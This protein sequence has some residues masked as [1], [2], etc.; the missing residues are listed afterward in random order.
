MGCGGQWWKREINQVVIGVIQANPDDGLDRGSQ[1]WSWKELD[2]VAHEVAL[3]G[4]FG[5]VNGSGEGKS[6]MLGFGLEQ[7]DT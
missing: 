2:T 5:I 3:V 7:L 4:L 6:M 1:Q